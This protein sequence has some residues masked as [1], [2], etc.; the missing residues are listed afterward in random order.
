MQELN[1]NTIYL[2][3]AK[4]V[5]SHLPDKSIDC[6]VT[7][8]PYYKLRDYGVSGQLGLEPSPE[9]YIDNLVSVFREVHRVLKDEGTLWVNLGDS[10]A[11]S[12][13]RWGG[14]KNL[15]SS[16]S[17][18]PGSSAQMPRPHSWEHSVIKPKD[19]IGIPWSLALALRAEGWYL[20]QDII[21]EKKN[22]Q[23][24]SVKDRCTK[25]HEYIFMLSKM[26]KY[27]YDINSI[28]EPHK[29]MDDLLRRVKNGKAEWKTVKAQA[30]SP[31]AMSGTGKDRRKNYHPLGR[32]KR[33][34]WTVNLTKTKEA[35]FATYPEQLIA[36]CVKAGCPEGGVV[37]DPFMGSGTSAVVAL[38]N[39]RQ[40][41]GIELNPEYIEMAQRRIALVK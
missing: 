25:A 37:L 15:S 36:D 7:S 19:L 13:G 9:E 30:G 29:S 2:G 23:P 6:C 24:E 28:R 31:F 10:Y 35:H 1:I 33:T 3:D 8:P 12:N 38:K 39:K 11:C 5:L 26:P 41:V 18:S 32:N 21:W 4:E 20:R 16:E 34:V 27:Y 17:T 22:C 14:T 40:Y